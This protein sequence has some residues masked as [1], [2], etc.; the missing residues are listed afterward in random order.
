MPG[1]VRLIDRGIHLSGPVRAQVEYLAR[2]AGVAPSEIVNF[3]LTEVFS[4]EDGESLLPEGVPADP[5]RRRAFESQRQRGPA[6]V[7]PIQRHRRAT[8]PASRVPGDYYDHAYLRRQAASLRQTA[9]AARARAAEVCKLARGARTRAEE[10][11]RYAR[12]R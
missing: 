5:L 8:A 7:I 2:L 1:K 6:D 4:G 12:R 11:L 9:H 10:F 3:V